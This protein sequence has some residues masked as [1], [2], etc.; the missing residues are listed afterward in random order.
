MSHIVV[1]TSDLAGNLDQYTKLFKFVAD[2]KADSIIIGGDIAPIEGQGNLKQFQRKFLEKALPDKVREFKS[3]LTAKIF[4][5]MGN[6]DCAANLDVLKN[7]DPALFNY[8][9]SVRRQLT[10]DFDVY[11]YSFVPITPFQLKDW[12]KFDTK[13]SVDSPKKGL[14]GKLGAKSKSYS[15][16]A[17]LEGLISTPTGFTKSKF[18][19]ENIQ[20]SIE[21]DL[22]QPEAT[23]NA[24]KTLYVMH[25]PPYDTVLDM[26]N[27]FA[28]GGPHIGS[29]AV[30]TFIEKNQPY[31]T[32]HG[33]IHET[34]DFSRFFK[35]NIG[36]T[37]SATA[38]NDQNNPYLQLVTF[39]LYDVP[40]TIKRLKL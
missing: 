26:L 31:M 17:R 28:G 36:A 24:S 4:L 9:H 8:I 32:L 38:G 27:P 7:N 23:Q 15:P 35:Q 3:S 18:D 12:E 2:N 22:S 11:G 19:P 20:T 21:D 16:N 29:K 33:H 34:V 30:R 1:Y 14:L 13:P 10:P 37:L 25:T 39:D 5:I 6:D 40:A